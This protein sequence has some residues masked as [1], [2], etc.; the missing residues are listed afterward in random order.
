MKE[1]AVWN[2]THRDG[3][4]MMWNDGSVWASSAHNTPQMNNEIPVI[5]AAPLSQQDRAAVT[6][7]FAL[8]RE[9]LAPYLVSLPKPIRKKLSHIGEKS[10]AFNAKCTEIMGQQPTFI[11]E[12]TDQ[13]KYAQ[14]N[15]DFQMVQGYFQLA[16]ALV[17]DLSNS[18]IVL[19]HQLYKPNLDL[20]HKLDDLGAHGVAA[21]Q[22]YH[23]DLSVK[24]PGR[25]SKA[26][27]KNKKKPEA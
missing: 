1:V 27:A 17:T 18:G 5:D 8:I 3:S 10:V 22:A 11:P 24:F 9:K 2:G 19:G 26:A 21:A 7:A 25:P 14:A 12:Y 16:N 20:Y 23:D 6:A 4:P 13:A 15:T